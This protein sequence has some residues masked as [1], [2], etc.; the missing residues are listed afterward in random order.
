M[1]QLPALV[2]PFVGRSLSPAKILLIDNLG[3]FL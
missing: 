2:I 1:K 3:Q